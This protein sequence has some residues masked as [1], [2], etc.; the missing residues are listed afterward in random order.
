MSNVLSCFFPTTVV[1]V[2]DDP[3]FLRFLRMNLENAP[4]VCKTFSDSYEALN[5]INEFGQTNRLDCSNLIKNGEEGTSEYKSILLDI[6]G[7]HSEIYSPMRFNKISAVISDYR[8]PNMNG[9]EFCSKIVDKSIQRI[10]LT[11]L[12][13]DRVGIEAFNAGY[14]SRF[15]RKNLSLDLLDIANRSARK[16]F[17]IYT[18]YVLQYASFGELGHLRDP[19]FSDFFHRIYKQGNFVEYYMLDP[20]GTYIL[21]TSTGDIKLLNVLTEVELARLV[22]V[23]I[24]SGEIDEESLNK[25]QSRKYMLVYHNRNGSLPPVAEWKKF[26]QPAGVL[27]GSQTYYYAISGDEIADI[28]KSEIISF[29]TFQENQKRR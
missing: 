11:G 1:L 13:E 21:M 16:F 14:I 6:S 12:A 27:E 15:S 25:L 2:D 17:S 28:N 20:F 7:L 4:F 29:D 3:A 24:A 8:M 10:L 23:A 19:V 18:D 9:V 5:F 22:D 26:L